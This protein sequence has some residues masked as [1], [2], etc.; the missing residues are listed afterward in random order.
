MS[1]MADVDA[2]TTKVLVQCPHCDQDITERDIDIRIED[3]KQELEED[4]I[5]KAEG[6]ESTVNRMKNYIRY[7]EDLTK[8]LTDENRSL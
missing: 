5:P 6:A 2:T 1:Q 4:L 3:F 7:L 8:V